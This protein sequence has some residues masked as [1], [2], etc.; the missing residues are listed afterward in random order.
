M[1]SIEEVEAARQS[2]L[3]KNR[4]IIKG[5]FKM[6]SRVF[7]YVDL[8]CSNIFL[9]NYLRI[10]ADD[11]SLNDT[12]RRDVSFGFGRLRSIVESPEEFDAN[13]PDAI[14]DTLR[15]IRRHPSLIR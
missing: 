9:E 5:L 14:D 8:V 15:Q 11:C 4:K 3:D 13:G 2:F 12:I 1:S 6:L 10:V 7:T